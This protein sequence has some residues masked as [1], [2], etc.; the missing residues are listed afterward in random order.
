MKVI[1][2]DA[3]TV[4]YKEFCA[5]D[6]VSFSVS[7]QEIFGIVGPN[8]AGKTSTVECI[9]GLRRAHSGKVSVVGLDP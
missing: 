1:D 6:G 4:K 8:G 3:L 5:V 7:E 2:V 9:A